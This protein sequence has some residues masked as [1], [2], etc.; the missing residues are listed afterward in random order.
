MNTINERNWQ[1]LHDIRKEIGLDKSQPVELEEVVA[2][3]D[4]ARPPYSVTRKIDTRRSYTRRN[5]SEDE[6]PRPGEVTMK[7]FIAT[8]AA[9]CGRS[10]NSIWHRINSGKYGVTIRRVNR[11][12]VYI[13]RT[14]PDP[15]L[16]HEPREGE[17]PMKQWVHDLAT[18]EGVSCNCIYNRV[19]RG[20]L[21]APN[22][23]IVNGRVSFVK[24]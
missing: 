14:G 22:K 12:L 20:T 3:S 10:R 18:A 9:R 4:R 19:L 1:M 21:I 2:P 15:I 11:H 8:E 5:P 6:K 13:T 17:I 16:E 7:E 23:R 24:P